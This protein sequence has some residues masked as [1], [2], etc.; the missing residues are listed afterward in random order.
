MYVCLIAWISQEPHVQTTKFSVH[1]T[2]ECVS[3]LL[4]WRY[5]TLCT[6]GFVDDVMFARKSQQWAT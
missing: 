2:T 3:V 1:V 4:W 6:F 5:S